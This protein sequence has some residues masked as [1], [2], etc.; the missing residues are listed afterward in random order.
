ML[1]KSDLSRNP[2]IQTMKDLLTELLG[3]P[4]PNS[5]A[6]DRAAGQWTADDEQG[7][8]GGEAL[9]D[10]VVELDD[11]ALQLA[12]ATC[13]NGELCCARTVRGS[14]RSSMGMLERTVSKLRARSEQTDEMQCLLGR[15]WGSVDPVWG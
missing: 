8:D 4:I 15:R 10:P 1:V 2:Q 14:C 11:E 12:T 9:Q 6:R 7:Q 3:L 5:R 13:Q